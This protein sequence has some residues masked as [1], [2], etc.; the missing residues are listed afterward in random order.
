MP[1]TD[2][3]DFG[4]VIIILM[5]GDSPVCY[6]T[7]DVENF[8]N[9]DAEYKWIQMNA[10]PC[11]KKV[12]EDKDAGILSFKMSINDVNLNGKIEFGDYPSW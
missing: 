8:M 3:R 12:K 5:D 1:Y 9:P 6:K 10:D 11:V 4:K 2:T 7:E